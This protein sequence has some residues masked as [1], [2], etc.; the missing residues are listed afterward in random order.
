M[1]T[2]G[3]PRRKP[4]TP[5]YCPRF[6]YMIH[7][8]GPHCLQKDWTTKYPTGRAWPTCSPWRLRFFVNACNSGP[9]S[10]TTINLAPWITT[11]GASTIDRK[12]F[13]NLVLDDGRI[14][15]GC[16]TWQNRGV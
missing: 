4:R 5:S 2:K 16:G 11:V 8:H 6:G 3:L 12:V 1:F 13:A 15:T 9:D 7:L 10:K 14:I